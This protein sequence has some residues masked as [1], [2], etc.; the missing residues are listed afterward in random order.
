MFDCLDACSIVQLFIGCISSLAGWWIINALCVPHLTIED[1]YQSEKIK[2]EM[3]RYIR[4][5]NGKFM[6]A[7]DV[8]FIAEF[9]IKDNKLNSYSSKTDVSYI[10][11]GDTYRLELPPEDKHNCVKAF[12][13]E[14]NGSNSLVIT[15]TYR[16][17]F[18]VKNTTRVKCNNK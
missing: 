4:I 10:E 11:R 14:V 7:Y 15:A 8:A 2:E 6:N 18:G 12:Y 17:K 16:N 9:R 1:N 13:E 3:K 5:K